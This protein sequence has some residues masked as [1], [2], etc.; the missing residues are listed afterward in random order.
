MTDPVNL[1]TGMICRLHKILMRHSRVL[2]VGIGDEQ[3]LVYTNIGLTRQATCTDVSGI[4]EIQHVKVQFCPCDEVDFELDVFCKRY[5]VSTYSLSHV[6]SLSGLLGTASATRYGP[7]C[8]SR[9]D[10]PC[11]YYYSSLRGEQAWFDTG[12]CVA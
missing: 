10:K 6:A 2:Q 8:S 1:T 12:K 9:L 3:R 4:L 7:F 11:I 5:N